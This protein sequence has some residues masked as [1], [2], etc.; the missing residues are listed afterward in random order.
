MEPPLRH[1][2]EDLLFEG[3]NIRCRK[4]LFEGDSFVYSGYFK[5]A[6]DSKEE[7]IV[8]R[9]IKKTDCADQWEDIF[10]KHFREK[11]SIKH[12]NVLKIISYEEEKKWR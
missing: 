2:E 6:E 11:N 4:K 12:E 3:K 7:E 9:K 1:K 10:S 5:K 8:V